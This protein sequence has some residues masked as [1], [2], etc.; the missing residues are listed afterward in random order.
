MEQFELV[1]E[2]VEHG[3]VPQVPV[4]RHSFCRS[5]ADFGTGILFGVVGIPGEEL[6]HLYQ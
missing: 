2:V 1:G 4:S 6:K 5:S 3:L